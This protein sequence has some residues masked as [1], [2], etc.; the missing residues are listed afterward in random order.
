MI[1]F[2]YLSIHVHLYICMY[3][4]R[5]DLHD[6]LNKIDYRFLIYGKTLT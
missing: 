5:V 1:F 4:A 2:K 6:S 3:L